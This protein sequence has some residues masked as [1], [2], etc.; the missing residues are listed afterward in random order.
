[1]LCFQCGSSVG[2]QDTACP[3]CGADLSRAKKRK[4]TLTGPGADNLQKFTQQL[5]AVTSEDRRI[6]EEGY[7]LEDRYVIGALLGRGP[8][9]Q[10]YQAIDAELDQPVAIKLFKASLF[11]EQDDLDRFKS[12]LRDARQRTAAHVARVHEGGLYEGQPWVCGQ[13]LEG[14]TLR[15]VVRLRTSK[16]ESFAPEE[17][18]RLVEQVAQGLDAIG[19]DRPHG[20]L[21][22]EN[23]LFL[24]D[25]IKITD[26][27]VMAAL[28]PGAWMKAL[29]DD[30]YLAPELKTGRG[31][32]HARC[33]VYSLGAIMAEMAFGHPEAPPTARCPEALRGFAALCREAMAK[34]PADR[35]PHVMAL[36]QSL[37]ATFAPAPSVAPPAASP[38]TP[39]AA[40][41]ASAPAL[42]DP[43]AQRAGATPAFGEVG[44]K[45]ALPNKPPSTPTAAPA[46]ITPVV[47]A[48]L[49]LEAAA[50]EEPEA[51][52]AFDVPDAPD[53]EL[54]TVEYARAPQLGDLL[55]THDLARGK[56]PAPR[57]PKLEAKRPREATAVASADRQV[58]APA[59]ATPKWAYAVIAALVIALVVM[60]IK[61]RPPKE[62]VNLGDEPVA[63]APSVS[64]PV[65]SP[66]PPTPAVVAA[67]TEAQR[68]PAR[69]LEDAPAQL[70]SPS[71]A[72]LPEPALAVVEPAPAVVEPAPAVLPPVKPVAAPV[73]PTTA[74]VVA[75]T[76]ERPAPVKPAAAVA[77]PEPTPG[78]APA[79]TKCPGGMT[80]V[81]AGSANVCVDVY[82][83]PGSGKPKVSVS[84]FDAKKSCE[85]KQKRLCSINEWQSACG[86]GRKYP[87]GASWDADK[88]NTTDE[89]DIERSLNAVGSFKGCR[90]KSGAY[91]MVGNAHEWVEEKRVAGGGFDSGEDVASCRY[92]SPKS[93][94]S[95][96]GYIGFRCCAD[97]E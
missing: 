4:T 30:P 86:G 74:Q 10:V 21:R 50:P 92:S 34:R 48:P 5:R 75:A 7:R 91:D 61:G 16:E 9:G 51:R 14:L 96:A 20:D 6:F 59:G 13:L 76:Q 29:A 78:A 45:P 64:D 97:P 84:W 18:A 57:Q 28:P 24:P 8:F 69:A 85:S 37:A 90:S 80:L 23:I 41:P 17:I 83:Y 33:D 32:L 42:P 68:A 31:E 87:Y 36:A 58:S 77:K 1:M 70:P 44:A 19:L 52:A 38:A 49:A 35:P 43:P 71:S 12:T 25:L 72:S 73:K 15:K 94:S 65:A 62:V 53:E 55:P 26:H 11:P 88:C 95:A 46:A 66:E 39:P 3:N 2:R 89:D 82:E 54:S 63:S 81:K 79:G 47:V 22:P 27:Y 56:V 67:L 60:V 40:P 93:P